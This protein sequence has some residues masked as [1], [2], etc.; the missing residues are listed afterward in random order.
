M[1]NSKYSD[2]SLGTGGGISKSD[3]TRTAVIPRKKNRIG[4]FRMLDRIRLPSMPIPPGRGFHIQET[5][6]FEPQT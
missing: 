6:H 4:G 3:F 1:A 5:L 2:R